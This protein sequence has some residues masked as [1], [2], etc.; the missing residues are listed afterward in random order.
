MSR[1]RRMF[2]RCKIVVWKAASVTILRLRVDADVVKLEVELVFE[3]FRNLWVSNFFYLASLG[4]SGWACP[5]AGVLARPS[6]ITLR[7]VDDEVGWGSRVLRLHVG[8]VK[9]PDRTVDKAC[10]I[11]RFREVWLR[12]FDFW[13]HLL[14]RYLLWAHATG[15]SFAPLT[16]GD[17]DSALLTWSGC[18]VLALL[19]H[20]LGHNL[21][22]AIMPVAHTLW[23]VFRH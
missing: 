16:H 22:L 11:L 14:S 19:L 13:K 7:I 15:G 20:W 12:R 17:G 10:H 21:F 5:L 3:V 1:S 9:C 23:I 18:H 4:A 6:N 8:V 2:L